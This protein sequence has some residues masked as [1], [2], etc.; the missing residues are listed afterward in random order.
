MECR[1]SPRPKTLR[2]T[3]KYLRAGGLLTNTTTIND[4]MKS[5]F[6]TPTTTA[7]GNTSSTSTYSAPIKLSPT[8]FL[9]FSGEIQDQD[10]YR[11]QIE[12]I[13]GQTAFKFL[14]S[15]APQNQEE[16]ERDEELFNVFK[17][18]F[19]DGTAYHLVDASRTDPQNPTG[20]QLAASG[21]KLWQDFLAWCNSGGRKDALIKKIKDDLKALRLDGDLVGGA[22]YVNVFITKH[23]DL[24][25]VGAGVDTATMMSDFIDQIDDESFK[26]TKELLE[27]INWHNTIEMELRLLNKSFMMLWNLDRG[28]WIKLRLKQWK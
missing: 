9:E 3:V 5:A 10:R 19:M 26:V 17:R 28:V 22:S 21:H 11:M 7:T 24:A 16:K 15:R 18:S 20:A 2:V 6:A 27:T 4:M 13:V 23:Q 8:D 25:C 14:L 12:S 1:I